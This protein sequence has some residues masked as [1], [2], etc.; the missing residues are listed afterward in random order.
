MNAFCASENFDA[1]IVFHSSQP[2]NRSRKLEFKMREHSGS[3]AK[4]TAKNLPC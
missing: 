4:K 3:R 1:F 2:G